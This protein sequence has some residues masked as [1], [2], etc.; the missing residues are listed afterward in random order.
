MSGK[1]LGQRRSGSG[2]LAGFGPAE[3]HRAAQPPVRT[4]N[5]P[6]PVSLCFRFR[7]NIYHRV[8]SEVSIVAQTQTL[9]RCRTDLSALRGLVAAGVVQPHHPGVL[10]VELGDLEVRV[11]GL[12]TD[13]PPNPVDICLYY[14]TMRWHGLNV[15]AVYCTVWGTLTLPP[16]FHRAP[17]GAGP[18]GARYS[19]AGTERL[20]PAARGPASPSLGI[21]PLRTKSPSSV[22]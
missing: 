1:F 19:A 16:W 20:Q 6:Q 7:A 9:T 2:G 12:E 21:S 17:P 5:S 10:D 3:P 18:A 4:A 8:R 14:V 15:R 13:A 22:R 11:A